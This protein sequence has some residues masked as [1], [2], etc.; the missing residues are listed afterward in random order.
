M[1]TR[2]GIVTG[3]R[4][5]KNKGGSVLVRL[6]QCM[7]TD[8]RDMQTVQLIEQ[9][10]EESNPKDGVLVVML[11]GGQA[12]KLGV[13]A[14]D[15]VTPV[16]DVGGKRIYSVDPAD[17]AVMAEVR[18]DPDGKITTTGPVAKQTLHP[19][20]TVVVENAAASFIMNPDGTFEFHGVSAAFDCPVSAPSFAALTAGGGTGAITGASVDVTGDATASGISLNSHTHPGDSGGTTGGPQ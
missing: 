10:G 9:A 12:F 2:L 17:G 20:G 19:D 18:L 16:M 13:A 11:P 1:E 15:G 5:A 4:T 6:L 7:V 8:R 14:G 3:R